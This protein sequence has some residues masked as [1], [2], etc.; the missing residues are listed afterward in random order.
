MTA[1][2]AERKVHEKEEIVVTF[3][4]MLAEP[5]RAGVSIM[6]VFSTVCGL[7]LAGFGLGLQADKPRAGIGAVISASAWL[8][9]LVVAG[10]CLWIGQ[11]SWFAR[12]TNAGFVVIALIV[13]AFTVAAWR[14]VRANP[15]PPG[16][17]IL[18]PGFEIP[19]Y[20]RH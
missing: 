2:Q 1:Q 16:L 8:L 6:V 5:G 9:S 7:A 17:E 3:R 10:V 14:E 11:A 13:L 19:K 4:K 15:P 12:G 18:P 20:G